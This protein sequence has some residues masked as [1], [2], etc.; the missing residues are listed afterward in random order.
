M[1]DNDNTT[2]EYVILTA[3]STAQRDTVATP[4]GAQTLWSFMGVVK[5][6]TAE[7]AIRQ[8]GQEG[9]HV[10]IPARSWKPIEAKS[11]QTTTLDLKPAE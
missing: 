7:S 9:R 10:A 6:R 5:A 1:A 4:T 2:T 11:K 8:H 3:T